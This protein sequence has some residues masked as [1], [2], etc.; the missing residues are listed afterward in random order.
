VHEGL[1]CTSPDETRNGQKGGK[2][3]KVDYRCSS[4]ISL[5]RGGTLLLNE[6]E[7]RRGKRKHERTSW[8]EQKGKKGT[9]WDTCCIYFRG[10]STREKEF[11]LQTDRKSGKKKHG[12]S[13]E[14][15]RGKA[16]SAFS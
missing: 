12:Q 9:V 10:S 8:P 13:E 2:G 1:T 6:R 11:F 14:E 7:K 3:A 16:N 4:V 15:A 5:K